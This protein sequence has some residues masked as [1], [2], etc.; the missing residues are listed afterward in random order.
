MSRSNSKV[1]ICNA[2]KNQTRINPKTK[3]FHVFC[4]ECLCTFPACSE[5]AVFEDD[6]KCAQH[7]NLKQEL[8]RCRL[9]FAECTSQYCRVCFPKVPRCQCGR[10]V[11]IS[12]L[13]GEFFNYCKACKCSTIKC[14]ED[15]LLGLDYCAACEKNSECKTCGGPKST[16][17]DGDS[18]RQCQQP[19]CKA[20]CGQK[21]NIIY[22]KDADTS[23]TIPYCRSCRCK[24]YGCEGQSI[25]KFK[26]CQ[27]CMTTSKHLC[28]ATN[29][30]KPIE[31]GREYCHEC[32][33]AYTHGKIK[34]PTA[35]CMGYMFDKKKVSCC[36]ICYTKVK[37]Q[38][39]QAQEQDNE[40]H[41]QPELPQQKA[42]QY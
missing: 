7:H 19:D 38:E 15:K 41:S 26:L 35:N 10:K 5:R 21:T 4:Q 42:Q 29:C 20:Q 28:A 37:E 1:K 23:Y 33:I 18:C 39:R 32:D 3:L 27:N 24:T 12:S 31:K 16:N 30:G 13:T 9:C 17:H 8:S 34:C 11:I 25:N 2:C 14:Q 22:D 40:Q 36:A 6:R